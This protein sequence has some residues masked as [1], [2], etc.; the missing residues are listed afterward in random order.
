MSNTFARTARRFFSPEA[1]VPFLFGSVALGVLSNAVFTVFTNQFGTETSSLLLIGVGSLLILAL[2]V[3]VVTRLVRP[4]NEP[5]SLPG[6]RAPA[7]RRG[8]IL[9]VSN[10]PTCA[11]AI[12]YHGATL[13]SVW[14]ICSARSLAV[15]KELQQDYPG[16]I[17]GD[18]LIINDVHD[19][20]EFFTTVDRIY[21]SVPVGWNIEDVISDFT[22]MTSSASVGLVLACL[23]HQRPL[24]YTPARYDDALNA[25]V[26]LD[27]IE[28]TFEGLK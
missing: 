8:L 3:W 7:K 24:Q 10:K 5:T 1:L 27:P 12:G 20:S 25:I 11:K 26:P 15:A 2:A 19:P 14:L 13:E 4:T 23:P 21:Q 6:K 28:I 18:P 9:L 17:V 16:R 22:G